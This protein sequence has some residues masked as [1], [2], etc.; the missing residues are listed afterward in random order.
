MAENSNNNRI[1]LLGGSFD[2]IHYGHL[3]LA[4][5]AREKFDLRRIFFIPASISPHKQ[6]SPVS[7]AAHRLSML[8][9]ALE[10][11]PAFSVSEIEL[12]RGGVSYTIDTVTQLQREDADR[13]ICLI[14]GADAFRSLGGWK[15]Y[16]RLLE[17][18]HCLVAT[19]PGFSLDAPQEILQRLFRDASPYAVDNSSRK[20]P[21]MLRRRDNGRCLDF[22]EIEP[23]DI[24]ASEIRKRIKSGVSVKNMLPP[25]VEHYIIENH[26]Y[27]DESRSIKE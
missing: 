16:E 4:D 22:F 9:L 24:S 3:G 15:E 26:L 14:L 2:P 7:P 8:R 18:C 27:Q 5:E 20:N 13:E 17:R 6:E 11:R 25:K 19:R 10:E 1:G 23:R 12:A 21:A